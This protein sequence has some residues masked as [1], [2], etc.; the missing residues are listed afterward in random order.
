MKK[1]EVFKSIICSIIISAAFLANSFGQGWC[2]QGPGKVKVGDWV[3]QN[4]GYSGGLSSND[5]VEYT[6]NVDWAKWTW[7]NVGTWCQFMV[8]KDVFC[9]RGYSIDNT[10]S[11]NI[12][13]N[14]KLTN[15]YGG[16]RVCIVSWAKNYDNCN[17][18]IAN[19]WELY[20]HE[21]SFNEPDNYASW[22]T[23]KG[24]SGICSGS[25]Y[26]M[27]DC[28]DG[29]I[30]GQWSLRSW[31]NT[32]RVSGTTDIQCLWNWWK[33]RYSWGTLYY[34]FTEVG[35]EG[36]PGSGGV[37][38]LTGHNMVRNT[39]TN[40]AVTGVSLSPISASLAVSATQQL[41]ATVLPTNAT[42]KTVSWT[43][44]NSSVASVNASGL[45]TGVAAG[46]ATITVTTQD[47]NKTAT[48]AVTVTTTTVAVTGVTVSP[49][50][51]SVA[52][53]ATT[54][55]IAT[56]APT[57]ATN[58]TVSWTS[59]N[60]SVASVNA[61][62]L[63]TGVA[64]GTASIT[65]TTQDGGKTA[66]CAITVTSGGGGADL[67]IEAESYC[68]SAGVTLYGTLV[69]EWNTG[70]YT[71]YCS[72][73]LGSGYTTLKMNLATIQT[74]SFVIRKGSTTGTIIGTVNFTSTGS[75]E[76]YQEFAC[77]LTGASGVQDIFVVGGG[78]ANFDYMTFSGGGTS[79][80]VTSVSV[81]PTSATIIVGGTQQLTATV[82]PSNATNKTVSWTSSNTAV[83][84]VNSSGVVT[85]VAAGSATITVT[86]QDGNKTATCAVTVTAGGGSPTVYEAE[87][88]TYGGGAQI[89]SASN[90]SNGQ[91]I[92]SMN[93][94]GS[95]TQ[96]SSV[97]GGTGGP[98]SLVIRYSNGTTST[99]TIGLY[100][101]GT[102]IQNVSFPV[103]GGWNTFSDAN[104]SISLSSGT[105]NTIKLQIGSGNAAADIDK[106]TVT[107]N[108]G[109]SVAVTGVSLSPISASIAVS[110][111]QQLTATVLPTNATNKTVSWSSSNSSVASVNASGLV[112][113]VAA[114]TASITVTTQDGNKTATCAVTVTTTTVAV[115][116]V[117]VS[118]T[119]ASVATGAT[120]TLT[121][122][123]APTNATNKTVS[124]TSSNT[125]VATVN[126]SGVVTGV[127]AG[128]ATI[129]VTTQ[130]GNKTATS[131][132][133]AAGAADLT[134]QVESFCQSFGISSWPTIIGNLYS[135]NYAKYCNINLSTGYSKLVFNLATTQSGIIYV[136]KG[137]T[138]GT[139]IGTL[140]FTST[141]GWDTYQQITIP[142]TGANGTQ[143]VFLV[144]GASGTINLDWIMFTNSTLKSATE[145]TTV[146]D[147]EN[148][149]T[150][151]PNPV[152][153]N[154]IL[155]IRTSGASNIKNIVIVDLAGRIKYEKSIHGSVSLN[156][157]G[158]NL[159]TGIYI[160]NVNNSNGTQKIKLMVK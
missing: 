33:S 95:Y 76:T 7:S 86:T 139:T 63:V 83:A 125:A 1:S 130:D 107:P 48:C 15:T 104:V 118:P 99:H 16:H 52:T 132:I 13:Y 17:W 39:T 111:T 58:K 24:E 34:Y 131:S 120:T 14:A 26:K 31:R 153:K 133:T 37:F 6:S 10:A 87:N 108:S 43:S 101:N 126:S 38:E 138:T 81:S 18:D 135:P 127:A 71:K 65:V 151:Y 56:V 70:D 77:S 140:N 11:M 78:S 20:I 91:V 40:V 92:G 28:G 146:S 96:V 49:T 29:V 119:T 110:A 145:I 9:G 5:C 30:D 54:T 142:L 69:G 55:L 19:T 100:V 45:V 79:I 75:W 64:A 97:N 94:V 122:T 123:V 154:E 68:A 35:V 57:N 21:Q 44:S 109:G 148:A 115:T 144:G 149:F 59:S 114:G 141:G 157:G 47:G 41:T 2:G 152:G 4:N 147:N 27:Y 93:A 90:A 50:T 42:N 159:K 67:K 128:S 3:V 137:S 103:T 8:S 72:I 160:V 60:S 143:D 102:F 32:P 84:T 25:T 158:L 23:Y 150:M 61:S 85:G 129:T 88:G 124:W 12:S 134:V 112:T 116:G 155:N 80:P 106:Y 82:L 136:R 74:G 46:S 51:A 22:C 105:G 62:G 156:I 53:G 98:A 117:T 66:T 73:N 89:Q 36:A 121:A 113:G